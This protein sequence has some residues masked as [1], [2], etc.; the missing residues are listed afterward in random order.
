MDSHLNIAVVCNPLAGSGRSVKLAGTITS[1]LKERHIRY[2]MFDK[3]WPASFDGF[4]DVWI[5]GGDGTLN[6]FINHYPDISIPLVLY[7]GGTGNDV[8]WLLYKE[9]SLDHQFE[10]A[11]NAKAKLIDAG[12][13]N[14]KLFINGVG[15]GFEGEI[16]RATSGKRKLPGKSSFMIAVLQN[17][18]F[19]HSQSYS[20][21]I[22]GKLE[23]GRLLMISVTNGKRVGGGFYISPGADIADGLLDLVMIDP[24]DSLNRIRY[25]PVIEKGKHM[26]LP[27]VH[28]EKIKKVKINSDE[29]IAAHTDG[30]FF[31]A[32]EIEI[33]VLPERFRF[34]Y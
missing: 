15:I 21:E 8:H 33:E 24:L 20:I 25:L 1:M 16:A 31:P 34:I 2:S 28:H 14:E 23:A 10:V 19:Y 11:L 4:S 30:E 5:V 18:F 27:F 26:S 29:I 9:M 22:E 17:I 32:K 3:N 6:Y 12:R 7:K 13:C